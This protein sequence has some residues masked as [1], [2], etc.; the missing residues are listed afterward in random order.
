VTTSSAG[1]SCLLEALNPRASNRQMDGK[2]PVVVRATRPITWA[3]GVEVAGIGASLFA[4]TRLCGWV[5]AVA[6]VAAMVAGRL[7]ALVY[8]LPRTARA[9][10]SSC[11]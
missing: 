11:P 10:D 7:A 4:L 2:L 8:L 3:S 9:L 5:G 6:A 1:A